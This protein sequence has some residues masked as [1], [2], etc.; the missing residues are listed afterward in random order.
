MR[1]PLVRLTR[2][3]SRFARDEGGAV[4]VEAV[5]WIPFFFFVL[6]LITDTSMAF[7]SKAQAYRLIETYNRGYAINSSWKA[8]DTAS[9]IKRQFRVQFPRASDTDVTVSFTPSSANG[10]VAT[11]ITYP[12]KAVVL[13]NTLNVLGGWKI[14]VQAMQYLERPVS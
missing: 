1:A 10:T 2:F 5:L 13:F 12:A 8:T 4:T 11:S 7:F 9:E 6:M 3:A 14:T